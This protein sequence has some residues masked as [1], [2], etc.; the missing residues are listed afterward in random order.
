MGLA[1][2]NL[3]DTTRF[4]NVLAPEV[5]WAYLYADMTPGKTDRE[6]RE[7]YRAA[8]AD[9]G[10]RPV[11]NPLWWAFR[12]TVE[13]SGGRKFDVDSVAKLIIDAFCEGM[14]KHDHSAYPQTQLYA[15]DNVD[16]VR[17]LQVI[18]WAPPKSPI[19]QSRAPHDPDRAGRVR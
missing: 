13:K 15:D 5:D 9:A 12:I 18:G 11:S 17:F 8:A 10:I 6:K 7:K 2:M 14:I 3:E 4:T 1:R 16:H 19:P